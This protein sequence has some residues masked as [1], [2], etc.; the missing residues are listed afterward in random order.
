M[1][2][3]FSESDLRIYTSQE[4]L[5]DHEV[6]LATRS[7][8]RRAVGA[9]TDDQATIDLY[10]GYAREGRGALWLQVPEKSDANRATRYLVDQDVLHYRYFGRKEELD[11]HMGEE[12]P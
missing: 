10:F 8:T 7:R 2:A 1:E 3:G 9:L 5:E 6:F 11:I 4:I 12:T